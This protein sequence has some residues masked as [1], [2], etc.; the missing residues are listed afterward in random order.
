LRRAYSRGQHELVRELRIDT[1]AAD[2]SCWLH[3]VG[4]CLSMSPN[5]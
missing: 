4:W 1:H 3:E 5:A 2:S